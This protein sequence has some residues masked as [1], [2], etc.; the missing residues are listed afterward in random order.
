MLMTVNGVISVHYKWFVLGEIVIIAVLG[1]FVLLRGEYKAIVDSG[2]IGYEETRSRL[3]SRE[4]HLDD[5]RVMKSTYESLNAERLEQLNELLPIGIEPTHI[6]SRL[7]AFA[8]A[9]N[10]QLI[11]ID[12][13]TGASGEESGITPN[14]DFAVQGK[15]GADAEASKVGTDLYETAIITVNMEKTD[16]SYQGLKTFLDSLESFVPVLDLRQLSFSPDSTTYALQLTTH[17]VDAQ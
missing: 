17:Y 8:Q 6:I 15:D 7:H 5:L 3:V 14:G 9:A 1:W 12:V 10:V 2:I 16:S 4:T 13:T 11:S